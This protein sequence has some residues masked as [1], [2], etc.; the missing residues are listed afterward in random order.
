MPRFLTLLAVLV[1]LFAQGL[2]AAAQVADH[3][4]YLTLQDVQWKVT[5]GTN[6]QVTGLVVNTAP[7]PMRNVEILVTGFDDGGYPLTN[8]TYRVPFVE[9]D[10]S[11]P[12]TF[13]GGAANKVHRIQT[14]IVGGTLDAPR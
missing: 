10:G 3:L 4:L 2:P 8:N 1:A 13:D 7:R 11:L 6:F 9:G 12:F 5:E 14:E